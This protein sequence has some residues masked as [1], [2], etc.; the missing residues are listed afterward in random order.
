MPSKHSVGGSSPSRGSKRIVIMSIVDWYII[1]WVI[2]TLFMISFSKE[3]QKNI[4]ED[5]L[6]IIPYV[7]MDLFSWWFIAPI[8]I[9][10]LV[11]GIYYYITGQEHKFDKFE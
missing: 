3:R 8:L 7:S 11:I 1:G 6:Q 2:T 9:Y 4:R 5:K 10:Y